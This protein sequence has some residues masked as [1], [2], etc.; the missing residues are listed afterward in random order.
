[1]GVNFWFGNYL[2]FLERKRNLMK[3]PD[4]KCQMALVC[5]DTFLHFSGNFFFFQL[6]KRK[7][8][9]FDVYVQKM[10]SLTSDAWCNGECLGSV[11]P[12]VSL[13]SVVVTNILVYT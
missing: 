12:L 1:M 10:L 5:C 13:D 6:K 7:E 4:F 8:E 9:K 3:S 2:I 11:L